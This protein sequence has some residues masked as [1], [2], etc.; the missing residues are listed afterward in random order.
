[1]LPPT[2]VVPTGSLGKHGKTTCTE[3]Y[4]TAQELTV[5]GGKWNEVKKKLGVSGGGGGEGVK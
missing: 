2:P 5:F 1:M 4:G 3:E